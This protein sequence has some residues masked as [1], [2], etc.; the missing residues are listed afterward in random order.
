M[1]KNF[2]LIIT[3]ILITFFFIEIFV[4]IFFPQDLQRYW[5]IKENRYGLN[6][7]KPNYIHNL[8]RYKSHRARYE[9]GSFHNRITLK[10]NLKD[11][12]KVLVL[13]D[14]FAFGWLLKDEDTFIHKLQK[15]NLNYHFINS[16]VGAWGSTHYTLFT[17]L[18]CKKI[19]PMKIF[20]FLNSDD[21]WRGYV[22]KLYREEN[23]NLIKIK[24]NNIKNITLSEFDKKIPFYKFLKSNSHLFMLTRNIIYNFIN[25]PYYNPW[26]KESYWPKPSKLNADKNLS[27]KVEDFNKKVFIKLSDISKECNSQLYIF[28]TNWVNP[29]KLNKNNANKYFLLNANKFFKGSKINYFENTIKM[30]EL[31]DNPMK[32][33]INIDFHPNAKGSHLIY[34]SVKDNIKHALSLK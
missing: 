34:L 19:S 25:K 16:S 11:K 22:S 10:K 3:S 32:Y 9:F 7:N 12:D 26:S 31:Y 5:V 24:K 1:K 29:K 15:D 20:V 27:K 21:L 4:R 6:I 2:I 18:F 8:H 13:G 17:E 14:S 30:Q 33:I 28:Y 23:G